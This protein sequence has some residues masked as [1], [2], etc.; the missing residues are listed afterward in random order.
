MTARLDAGP[1]PAIVEPRFAPLAAELLHDY[2]TATKSNGQP[3]FTGARFESLGGAWN[4]PADADRITTADVVAVSCLSVRIP[5]VAA[6]RILEHQAETIAEYLSAMPRIGV[7]F[8]ETRESEIDLDS[9]AGKL[10]Q[11][12]RDGRDG[13]GPTTVSK[14]MARKRA[15]LVPIYERH[16]ESALDLGDSA[17]YWM[18]IR[19]LMLSIVDGVPLY[20]RLRAMV[21]DVGLSSLVTPLRAFDVL[22]WYAYNPDDVIKVR[23]RNLADKLIAAGVLPQ[24]EPPGSR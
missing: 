20:Q 19:Q 4:N 6:I 1:L 14:L 16:V 11:L 3:W 13:L 15:D 24:G 17:G 5:G 12:L 21:G 7:T 10:W 18:R 22:V 9:A 2:Y 23:A 8:W